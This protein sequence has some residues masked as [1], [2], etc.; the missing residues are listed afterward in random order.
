MADFVACIAHDG[1]RKDLSEMM[2][3]SDRRIMGVF[4]LGIPMRA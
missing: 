1:Y 3:A 2:K 4:G